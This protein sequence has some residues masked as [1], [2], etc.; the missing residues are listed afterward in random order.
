MTSHAGEPN[1]PGQINQWRERATIELFAKMRQPAVEVVEHRHRPEAVVR[2]VSSGQRIGVASRE[3]IVPGDP[4]DRSL[5]AEIRSEMLDLCHALIGPSGDLNMLIDA[6]PRD[7]SQLRW[8]LTQFH[9]WLIQEQDKIRARGGEFPAE[10]PAVAHAQVEAMKSL[11]APKEVQ[12]VYQVKLKR[13]L[14][15]DWM[16]VEVIPGEPGRLGWGGF[17]R[18]GSGFMVDR[19]DIYFDNILFG[20]IIEWIERARN[21]AFDGPLWLLLRSSMVSPQSMNLGEG[22]AGLFG[23]ERFHEVWLLDAP[24]SVFDLSAPAALQCLYP[25]A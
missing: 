20:S 11:R 15:L 16:H 4:R 12:I 24:G 19:G 10:D 23:I 18:F 13:I 8:W 25:A 3:L 2:V 22:I 9:A 7:A 21:Y 17:S 6:R 5:E 1:M 14:D